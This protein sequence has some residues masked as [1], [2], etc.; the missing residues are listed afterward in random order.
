MQ[1]YNP[2]GVRAQSVRQLRKNNYWS[3]KCNRWPYYQ[4]DNSVPRQRV[5][6][7]N[8][9]NTGRES[10]SVWSNHPPW[11]FILSLLPRLHYKW[12]SRR[13][14]LSTWNIQSIKGKTKGWDDWPTAN[15]IP[16]ILCAHRSQLTCYTAGKTPHI[17]S[18]FISMAPPCSLRSDLTK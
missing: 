14:D 18:A 3:D 7:I 4:C 8:Y 5:I 6:K 16:S 10:A 17:H 13:V 2:P 11:V 12:L 9:M 1:N 15:N